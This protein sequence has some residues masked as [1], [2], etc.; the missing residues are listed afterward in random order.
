[1]KGYVSRV[2]VKGNVRGYVRICVTYVSEGVL[3]GRVVPAL[4]QYVH[5]STSATY[6]L[7]SLSPRL[8]SAA[9]LE[10]KPLCLHEHPLGVVLICQKNPPVPMMQ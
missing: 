6:L 7:S 5:P 4:R 1:M 10:T 2:Y 8:Q 3:E 9:V